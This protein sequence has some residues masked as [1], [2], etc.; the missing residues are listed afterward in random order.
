MKR[1]LI[2]LAGALVAL[3]VTAVPAG[4][5]AQEHGPNK[6][7][8]TSINPAGE[9]G[10]NPAHGPAYGA[11]IEPEP[12]LE[13]TIICENSG[14]NPGPNPGSHPAGLSDNPFGGLNLGAWNAFF[15]TR[16]TSTSICGIWATDAEAT[17]AGGPGAPTC[18]NS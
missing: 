17:A 9:T 5:L 2:A 1:A 3:T 10:A 13:V 8:S 12:G 7:P 16:G 18:E 11:T 6:D 14:E 15:Q 4:A